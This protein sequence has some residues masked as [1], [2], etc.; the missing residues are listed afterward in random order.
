[1]R[2]AGIIIE[3]GALEME[4]VAVEPNTEYFASQQGCVFI[5]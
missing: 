3:Q 5:T 4:L 2:I 1:M